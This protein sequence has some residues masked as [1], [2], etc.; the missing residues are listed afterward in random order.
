MVRG[1]DH[2][3]QRIPARRNGCQNARMAFRPERR[4]IPDQCRTIRDTWM[5][6]WRVRGIIRIVR[7][8]VRARRST[9]G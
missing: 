4:I 3:G 8:M 2:A 1:A 7:T 5:E 9:G 6:T